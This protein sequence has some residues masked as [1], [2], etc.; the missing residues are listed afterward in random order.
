VFSKTD[1]E[2]L[3]LVENQRL[4]QA[5][6]YIRLP[7]IDAPLRAGFLV[8][9]EM[10]FE[11]DAS[12]ILTSGADSRAISM[13]TAENLVAE[14][15]DL[16]K[17]NGAPLIHSVDA[18]KSPLWAAA[19]SRELE[20]IRLNQLPDGKLANDSLVFDFGTIQILVFLGERDGME[21]AKF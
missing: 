12:L 13:A 8:F 5:N 19:L 1:L 20:G 16:H 17:I 3:Q 7:K 9:L 14:A 6:Y 18:L 2:M 21:V 4:A 11:N 10:V 15:T